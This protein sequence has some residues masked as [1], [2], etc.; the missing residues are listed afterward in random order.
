MPAMNP[1]SHQ[2]QVGLFNSRINPTQAPAPSRQQVQG[3]LGVSNTPPDLSRGTHASM[4]ND[5][6]RP[7]SIEMSSDDMD[8]PGSRVGT[9]GIGTAIG[10]LPRGTGYVLAAAAV[11]TTVAFVATSTSD[12][13][14]TAAQWPDD[15]PQSL[16]LPQPQPLIMS[17]SGSSANSATVVGVCEQAINKFPRSNGAQVYCPSMEKLQSIESDAK[18]ILSMARSM[19]QDSAVRRGELR[20]AAQC[21]GVR[22]RENKVEPLIAALRAEKSR[23][24]EEWGGKSVDH[25]IRILATQMQVADIDRS[26]LVLTRT[27]NDLYDATATINNKLLELVG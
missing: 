3:L 17:G 8:V 22:F 11:V 9:G 4:P 21:S 7:L 2:A 1:A 23:L 12:S 16:P 25:P 26:L 13:L 27:S 10:R 18:S 15:V 19:V 5:M 20:R 24:S 6:Y 14:A